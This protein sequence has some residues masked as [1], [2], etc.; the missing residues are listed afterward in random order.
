MACVAVHI[1]G[2]CTDHNTF[3]TRFTGMGQLCETG[4]RANVL[5]MLVFMV[6][7]MR[8]FRRCLMLAIRRSRCPNKLE[9]CKNQQ[10][11]KEQT[12]HGCADSN[13]SPTQRSNGDHAYPHT[14]G[15]MAW[16]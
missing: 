14:T 4:L 7:E 15:G 6:T 12:A 13:D 3:S 8:C 2:A 10:K 1:C 9:R 11:N 16:R 5:L